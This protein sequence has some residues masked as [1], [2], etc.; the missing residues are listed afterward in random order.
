M[1][2]FG[3]PAEVGAVLVSIGGYTDAAIGEHEALALAFLMGLG[4]IRFCAFNNATVRAWWGHGYRVVKQDRDIIL[5][6]RAETFD[7]LNPACIPYLY[8]RCNVPITEFFAIPL[9]LADDD[10][11]EEVGLRPLAPSA[12]SLTSY[13][14]TDYQTFDERDVRGLLGLGVQAL[15]QKLKVDPAFAAWGSAGVMRGW[16]GY[17]DLCRDALDSHEV[18][19]VLQIVYPVYGERTDVDKHGAVGSG[20]SREGTDTADSSQ[21]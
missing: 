17:V 12:S 13:K 1:E 5:D 9:P 2:A 11:V 18:S 19:P 7:A 20:A 10:D 6:E 21:F 16:D 4:H 15:S 8:R 14:D 3:L